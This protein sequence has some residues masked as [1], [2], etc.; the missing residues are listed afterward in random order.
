MFKTI[1]KEVDKE[2]DRN[3]FDTKETFDYVSSF[4]EAPDNTEKLNIIEIT[5]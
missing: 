5:S 1:E 3:T 4:F 2:P